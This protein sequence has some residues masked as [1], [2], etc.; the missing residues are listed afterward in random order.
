LGLAGESIGFAGQPLLSGLDGRGQLLG[1]RL[2][3]RDELVRRVIGTEGRK[4]SACFASSASSRAT[5]CWASAY[6]ADA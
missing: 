4:P 6:A 5:A 2:D 3:G 1:R